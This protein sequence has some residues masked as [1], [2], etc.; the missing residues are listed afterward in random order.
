MPGRRRN[1]LENRIRERIQRS[2]DA[3]FVRAD[4]ADL[5]RETSYDQV[6][7]ALRKLTAAGALIKA[8]YGLYVRSAISPFSGKVVP[9][10]G[11]GAFKKL[12]AQKLQLETEPTLAEQRYNADLSTQVPTGRVLRVK[13]RI[14]RR[15][16]YN[17]TLLTYEYARSSDAV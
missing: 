1:S 5:E 11:L 2:P 9:D 6:G 15:L 8:G 10:I 7:R 14:Q 3:V 4:F 16:V 12:V 13:G 17:G